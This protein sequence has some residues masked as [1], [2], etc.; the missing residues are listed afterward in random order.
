G[1]YFDWQPSVDISET[2]QEYLFRAALPAVKKEDVE[3][4]FADGMLTLSGERRQKEER[5]DEKFYKVESF[6]GN[7][8]RS[9]ALP[10]GIEA[11]A[12]RAES[13]DGVLTVHVPKSKVETKKP[14]TI[15][16]Q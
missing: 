6:Y 5:K 10:E 11:D 12:I 2:D 13:K 8:S 14:T 4:T 1:E 3:I 7:F 9:F 16:V 15:I